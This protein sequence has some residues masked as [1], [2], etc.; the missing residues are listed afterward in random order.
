MKLTYFH[1]YLV[2][3]SDTNSF[4]RQYNLLPFLKKFTEVE[5]I[6]FRNSFE[7]MDGEKV[8]MLHVRSSLF[9]FII[10]RDKDII[11][12]I[13]SQDL[14]CSDI[15]DRL[16]GQSVGFASYIDFR[17]PYYAMASTIKGPKN[18]SLIQFINDLLKKLQISSWKF[19]SECFVTSSSREEVLRMPFIG[20]TRIEVDPGNNFGR[21]IAGFLGH[22][23]TNEVDSY[24]VIVKPRKRQNLSNTSEKT[25]ENIEDE[26]LR[27]LIVRA[28]ADLDEQLTDFYI[29]T[30]GALSDTF[31]KGTESEILDRICDRVNNNSLLN[32]KIEELDE[33]ELYQEEQIGSIHNFTESVAWNNYLRSD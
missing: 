27:K 19:C 32:Q 21:A 26:G 25:F 30:Q 15:H 24:E 17:S 29:T 7:S 13:N 16:N 23:N 28:K 10:T 2:P 3:R 6:D 12:A 18:S 5:D 4:R 1:Y 14:S 11:K 9:L 8:Y 31:T 20:R 33:D 22:G